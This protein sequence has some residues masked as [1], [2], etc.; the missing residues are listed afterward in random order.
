[1]IGRYVGGME[2]VWVRGLVSGPEVGADDVS[3][4]A[5]ERVVTGDN[6]DVDALGTL[7][8]GVVVPGLGV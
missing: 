7:R 2:G 5:L 6:G 3:T 4:D 8:T 1:M